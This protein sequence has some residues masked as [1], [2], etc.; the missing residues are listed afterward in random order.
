MFAS[1]FGVLVTLY[2]WHTNRVGIPFSSGKALRIMQITT[3]MVVILIG[4]SLYTIHRQGA[5]P[6]P[7]PTLD[8]FKFSD[9]ALG[10]LRGTMAPRIAVVAILIGLGHSLLAMSG[11]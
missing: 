6:I 9:E 11:E 7:L 3:V 2:F 4:W 1:G 5:Q 8:N 10:W